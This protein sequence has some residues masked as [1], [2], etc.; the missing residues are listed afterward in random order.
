MIQV[1]NFGEKQGRGT[2]LVG[3][4]CLEL[5]IGLG[6]VVVSLVACQED[7]SRSSRDGLVSSKVYT[8]ELSS[9]DITDSTADPKDLMLDL[10]AALTDTGGG[11]SAAG[12]DTPSA[13]A[14]QVEKVTE[15]AA[16]A[17]QADGSEGTADSGAGVFRYTYKL[18]AKV[19][20]LDVVM[21]INNS[22]SMKSTLAA[23]QGQMGALMKG[24]AA[25]GTTHGVD[26]KAYMISCDTS[27]A[28][29][30]QC[31]DFKA[32]AHPQLI[33]I[34]RQW[35]KQDALYMLR[36]MQ[37][38]A[39]SPTDP[40]GRALQARGDSTKMFVIVSDGAA[41]PTLDSS[42]I[43]KM[44]KA[45]GRSSVIFSSFSSPRP[46]SIDMVLANDPPD[47]ERKPRQTMKDR[48]RV[49]L[50]QAAAYFAGQ[51]RRLGGRAFFYHNM[52]GSEMSYAH[53]YEFLAK[54]YQGKLYNICAGDWMQHFAE[55]AGDVSAQLARTLSLTELS[56]KSGLTIESVAMGG[57]NLSADE[58]TI[59]Q[60]QPPQLKLHTAKDGAEVVITAAYD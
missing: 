27:A 47:S 17:S 7:E 13:P 19:G 21:M 3:R 2:G 54:Y 52:C 37:M 24:L 4:Y 6:L 25:A 22:G 36:I 16:S 38:M 1:Q 57:V 30:M 60:D 45:F 12:A 23:M 8:S 48:A 44:N 46:T 31:L 58:Y 34:R 43:T 9:A 49:W 15:S 55:L 53:V 11:A 42:F 10:D 20:Q 29:K 26:I 50:P 40:L 5:A 14:A 39:L 56:G 28:E 32:I 51:D 35:S 59:T 33:R 41:Y 18:P